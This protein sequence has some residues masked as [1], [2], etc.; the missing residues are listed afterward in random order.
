VAEQ[1]KRVFKTVKVVS[2]EPKVFRK[3]NDWEVG[4]V[5]IGQYHSTSIDKFKKNNYTFK[6]IDVMFKNGENDKYL[7]KLLTLNAAGKLNTA[8]KDAEEGQYFQVEYCGL[9]MMTGGDHEGKDAHDMIITQL[10][11][12][13]QDDSDLL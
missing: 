2:G 12:E 7:G 10:A 1:S 3:W 5:F 11:E 8:M 4:D 13:E 9:K 6:A